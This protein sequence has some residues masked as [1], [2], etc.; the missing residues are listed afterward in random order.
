MA[1]W[2]KNHRKIEKWKWYK[3]P[4]YAHVWQHLIRKAQFEKKFNI[5]GQE[6]KRGEVD[7]SLRQ[8]SNETGVSVKVV[9]NILKVLETG[10]EIGTVHKGKNTKDLSII[11]ITNYE[12]Y[13]G[14]SEEG[15]QQRARQGH[16][17]GT[18]RARQ[19][20]NFKKKEK[21]KNEKNNIYSRAAHDVIDHLNIKT[22]K[23]YKHTSKA[24]TRFVTARIKDGYSIQDIKSV[25]DKKVDEWTGSDMEKYLRPETLFNAT[26]FESYMN[27]DKKP[28]RRV[29][30]AQML[31][32]AE[33]NE[34]RQREAQN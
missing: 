22:G 13:Q 30:F 8:L 25:I 32:E 6:V 17:K 18:V 33:E 5:N 16:S 9:R 34:R 28:E 29:D 10:T 19:G 20:H 11:S 1:G 24:T 23:N 21:E 3:K 12:I 26:K 14:E 2:V 15:A 31:K 27:E 7:F 4:S